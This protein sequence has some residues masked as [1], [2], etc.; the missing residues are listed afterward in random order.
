[1]S[2]REPLER[3][4]DVVPE[5]PPTP[6]ARET[7]SPALASAHRGLLFL[8]WIIALVIGWQAALATDLLEGTVRGALVWLGTWLIGNLGL[9]LVEKIITPNEPEE[10]D[11]EPALRKKAPKDTAATP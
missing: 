8:A 6:S 4:D 9:S 10:W 3:R 5:E 11:L 1:M 2:E 7:W